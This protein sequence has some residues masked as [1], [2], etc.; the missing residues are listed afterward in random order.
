V[1]RLVWKSEPCDGS[2]RAMKISRKVWWPYN[3]LL[4]AILAFLNL[5]PTFDEM[6]C[7]IKDDRPFHCHVD[8]ISISP[9]LQKGNDTDVMP[10]HSSS[11]Q[12]TQ[13]VASVIRNFLE[14]QNSGVIVILAWEKGLFE[15]GRVDVGQWVALRIP[16]PETEIKTTNRGVVVIDY[17]DLGL[18]SMQTKTA[19]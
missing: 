17:Y 14:V 2:G 5:V 15:V 10:R 12:N 19:K 3:S 1:F 6:L 11:L 4:F 16:S 18:V 7:D 13:S 8:L 9:A